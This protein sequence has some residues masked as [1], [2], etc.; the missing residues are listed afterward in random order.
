MFWTFLRGVEWV[1]CL[2]L[3]PLVFWENVVVACKIGSFLCSLHTLLQKNVIVFFFFWK[4]N[5]KMALI[6]KKVL[7]LTYF[8][9]FLV[10]REKLQKFLQHI[11]YSHTYMYFAYP[12][13]FYS[14]T[15]FGKKYELI[16]YGF[17]LVWVLVLILIC[18]F[19]EQSINNK[20]VSKI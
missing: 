16:R 8:S 4:S 10:T 14:L 2:F 15:N 3:F 6:W 9:H 11:S 5:F 1:R 20:M 19:L 18:A 17:C 12:I 7:F 13:D